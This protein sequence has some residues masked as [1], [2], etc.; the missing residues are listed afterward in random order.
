MVNVQLTIPYRS[1][2]NRSMNDYN[3]T[4]GLQALAAA[5]KGR[6][7]AGQLRRVLPDLEAALAAG[8]TYAALLETLKE[9][10]LV[11]TVGTFKVTL[12]RLRAQQAKRGVQPKSLVSEPSPVIPLANRVPSH[13]PADLDKIFRSQPDMNALAKLGRQRIEKMKKK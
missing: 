4:T 7:K 11:M 6:S 2:T 5:G 8:A 13:D 12:S 1:I 3:L 10:G 9:H